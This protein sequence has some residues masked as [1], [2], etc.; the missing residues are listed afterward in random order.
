[1]IPHRFSLSGGQVN[2]KHDVANA[3]MEADREMETAIAAFGEARR[4]R[5]TELFRSTKGDLQEAGAE[6]RHINRG[7]HAVLRA[8]RTISNARR[9]ALEIAANEPDRETLHSSC[10][11]LDHTFREMLADLKQRPSPRRLVSQLKRARRHI[12]SGVIKRIAQTK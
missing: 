6:D 1:M 11:Q 10:N 9:S 4:M 8:E 3:L 7:I 12:P 2:H 5:W